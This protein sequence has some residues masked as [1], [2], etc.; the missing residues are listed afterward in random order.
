MTTIISM[1]TVQVGVRQELVAWGS[2]DQSKGCI[3]IALTADGHV[4][5]SELPV[6][7]DSWQTVRSSGTEA[8][9]DICD[10]SEHTI[11]V[12]RAAEGVVYIYVDGEF[13]GKGV[14]L[15]PRPSELPAR[16][17]AAKTCGAA[18]D[19]FIFTGF[20]QGLR[21]Y[22]EALTE[23]QIMR[24]LPPLPGTTANRL[25]LRGAGGDYWREKLSMN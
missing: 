3:S 6:G 25:L 15:S 7:Q 24:A 12:S 18:S 4:E 9:R 5:Y 1:E 8:G 17:R 11:V 19:E 13:A 2:K 16:A 14:L 23:L 22:P 21:I 10:G 20:M